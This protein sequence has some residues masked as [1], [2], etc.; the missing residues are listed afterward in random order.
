MAF[1]ADRA[2]AE[3]R[4]RGVVEVP[5]PGGRVRARRRSADSSRADLKIPRRWFGSVRA[6]GRMNVEERL[7]IPSDRHAERGERLDLR[8]HVARAVHDGVVQRLDAEP[9]ARGEQHAVALVPEGEGVLAA[10]VV[11]ARAPRPRRGAARSRCPSGCGNDGLRSQ[12][13]DRLE[14]VELAVDDDVERSSSLAIG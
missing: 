8:R 13:P 4:R 1:A 12:P 10:Q 11:Q 7:A 6:S 3:C 2:G 5:V 9:V 14:V